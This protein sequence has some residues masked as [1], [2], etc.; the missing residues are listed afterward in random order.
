MK[1]RDPGVTPVAYLWGSYFPLS[2]RGCWPSTQST[3]TACATWWWTRMANLLPNCE[4]S[5]DLWYH[6]LCDVTHSL[7][8]LLKTSLRPLMPSH[9]QTT[10]L[11][12]GIEGSLLTQLFH[13]FQQAFQGNL[14]GNQST[15]VANEVS[16]SSCEDHRQCVPE[17][18]SSPPLCS[19]PWVG[20]DILIKCSPEKAELDSTCVLGLTLSDGSLKVKVPRNSNLVET[21]GKSTWWISC[22]ELCALPEKNSRRRLLLFCFSLEQVRHRKPK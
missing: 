11:A 14:R 6:P 16:I 8:H 20:Q 21:K 7:I 18:G 3:V 12:Q 5:K 1:G 17:P 10:I 13:C 22:L 15:K 19:S 2:V 9:R 4:W